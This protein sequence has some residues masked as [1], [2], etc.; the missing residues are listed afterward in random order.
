[1]NNDNVD[2]AFQA[3][4]DALQ[5]AQ[6]MYMDL[7]DAGNAADAA[8]AKARA[9]RIQNEIDNLTDKQLADWQAGA[10]KLIPQLTQAASD[11]QTAITAVEQDLNNAQKV[12]SAM[13]TLDQVISVAMKFIG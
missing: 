6:L 9:G 3:L 8:N 11:S 5:S 7:R 12:Q 2:D 1:M 10:Q 4:Q 13:Q